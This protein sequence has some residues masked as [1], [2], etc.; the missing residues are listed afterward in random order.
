MYGFMESGNQGGGN[1]GCLN[2]IVE[3]A[4]GKN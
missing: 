3:N 4:L 2:H 1:T